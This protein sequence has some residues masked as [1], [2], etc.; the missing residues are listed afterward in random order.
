MISECSSCS[1]FFT[2]K[3]KTNENVGSTTISHLM[4]GNCSK[5]KSEMS[6]QAMIILYIIR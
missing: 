1:T 6:K 2:I 4:K 3:H 5:L